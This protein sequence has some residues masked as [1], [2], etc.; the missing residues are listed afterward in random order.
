MAPIGYINQ[1][2]GTFIAPDP[3]RFGMMQQ[4]FKLML[5]GDY[6]V[7]R[8][9]KIMDEEWDFKTM[10]RGSFGGRRVSIQSLHSAF[11]NPAYAGIIIDPHT[12]EMFK[13]RHKPMITPEEFDGIQDLIGRNGMPRLTKRDKDFP[14]RGFLVCGQCGCM[15]TAEEKLKTL[16]DGTKKYYR[17]YH[18]T[19]KGNHGCHQEAVT[20]TAL[21]AQFDA[22]LDQY[23]L[24]PDLYELGLKALREVASHETEARDITQ[25]TQAQSIKVVQ[26]K[27]D[28]L[29]DLVVD[30]TISTEAY[31]K[32]TEE[33]TL[34]LTELQ[35]EQ[36]ETADRA[37]DWYDIVESTLSTLLHARDNF[38]NGTL[39]D[40]RYILKAIG[41]NPILTEKKIGLTPYYWVE[42]I[43][44][45]KNN[46]TESEVLVRT[47][48]EQIEK[49]SNEAKYQSWCEWR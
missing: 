12:G 48:P 46:L 44:K 21:E 19:H 10:K 24:S 42:E 11:R 37:K 30:G 29:L 39:E 33:L 15:I 8:I 26:N 1:G 6:S 28:N 25:A 32:K 45:C 38:N 22:L 27:L 9:K 5:T 31:Q 35:K 41:S 36:K 20:E 23:E 34:R 7:A 49:A 2:R 14:L 4:A 3:K 43:K 13:A 16:K 18:C 17:Y 40:K 47:N